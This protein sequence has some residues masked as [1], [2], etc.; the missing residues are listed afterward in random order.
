MNGPEYWWK[1]VGTLDNPQHVRR[2]KNCWD[3]AH[4]AMNAYGWN[5]SLVPYGESL[6]CDSCG[7]EITPRRESSEPIAVAKESPSP[8]D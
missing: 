1:D 7:S 4:P 3:S 8:S 2:C 6:R 5:K